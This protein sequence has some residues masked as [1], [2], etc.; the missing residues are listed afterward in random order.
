MKE[1]NLNQTQDET[2]YSDQLLN[3]ITT[4]FDGAAFKLAIY[5]PTSPVSNNRIH[6]TSYQKNMKYYTV[7]AKEFKRVVDGVCLLKRKVVSEFV[8]NWDR[9]KFVLEVRYIYFLNKKLCSTQTTN[10][11]FLFRFREKRADVGNYEKWTT[12]C[13]CENLQIDDSFI[14]KITQEKLPSLGEGS[15]LALFK[16]VSI[17]K[18]IVTRDGSLIDW[19]KTLKDNPRSEFLRSVW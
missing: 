18:A 8:S 15:V 12:D 10:K 11:E 2:I 1:T 14:W 6:R 3:S 19:V 7:E 5:L 9:D 17:K 16:M 13:L 4:F